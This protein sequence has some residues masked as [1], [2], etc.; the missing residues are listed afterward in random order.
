VGLAARDSTRTEAGFPLYGHELAGPYSIDPFEAGFAA[1]IKL[2]KPFFVGRE[3]CVDAYSN[4]RREIVRF[5]VTTPDA[6]PVH[7]GSAIIDR[8]GR[9]LGR[10]TSCVSLGETQVGM[11]ILDGVGTVQPGA[12][13][14]ILEPQRRDEA[15]KGSRD[16]TSG[17]RVAI[18]VA[19]TILTRFPED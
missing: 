9:V 15:A 17:D 19:A 3:T 13:V 18:P 4:I 5:E 1:Y 14:T 7:D 11:A 2:H 12:S 16:L 6:R 10:V 8:G